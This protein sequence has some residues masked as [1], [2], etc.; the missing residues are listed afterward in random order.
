MRS[1][2]GLGIALSLISGCL[3]LALVAELSYL[4]WWKTRTNRARELLHLFCW[5]KPS[6]PGSTEVNPQ[7]ISATVDVAACSEEGQLQLQLHSSSSRA[8][9][10]LHL[11]C[12]RKPSFPGSTEVN[13]QE[14]SATVD[15]AACS[16]EGQLQLQLHSS[17]SRAREPLH[18]FCWRKPYFP[19]STEVNPQE[20]SAT[21]DVAACSEEGQLQLQLHSSS[22]RARELLHLFC[23]RKP[24]FPSSTEV[25]PQEISATV[26]V[27]ACS[28]EG[29]LQLQLHSSSSRARELLHLFCWRKPS[30]PSSTEVN[31]QEIS[32]TVDVA[33]CSEEG[34]L[35]LQLHSSSSRAR[36]L[37]H[38]FCWRKPSV[39]SSTEVN[40]QEI[41][42]TVDVAA[43]SEEGQLRVQSSSSN[44]DDDTVEAELMRLH[45]L[46]GPPRFLFTINEESKEDLESED[47][48]SGGKKSW[49]DSFDRSDTPPYLTP[50]SSPPFLTPPLTPLARFKHS[51]FNPLF[52]SSK[53]ED[54]FRI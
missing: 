1:L 41:S 4:F 34:Q 48:R 10:L 28:E 38:L 40:P 32:A 3:F 16:E 39:P 33:A 20:I 15:V 35:Q 25:N 51:A 21:V 8:R 49:S 6:F 42:A 44:G 12:W 45:S 14:I 37:L 22:S 29:Q 18:L 5:R 7:E 26:D 13:P 43:C 9:E 50:P 52:E 47:V 11:F 24:S 30:V 46:A 17:S 2:T 31:P 54:F 53:E 36:E 27:A 19:G 23:W